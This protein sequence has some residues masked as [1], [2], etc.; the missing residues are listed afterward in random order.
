MLESMIA[1]RQLNKCLVG[2]SGQP[3][4]QIVGLFA[5]NTANASSPPILPPLPS[6]PF[7]PPSTHVGVLP[8]RLL[9]H[10]N[11]VSP[12]SL[13]SPPASTGASTSPCSRDRYSVKDTV[14][15]ST[16]LVALLTSSKKWARPAFSCLYSGPWGEQR[17]CGQQDQ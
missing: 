15:S 14:T 2:Q 4:G 17:G 13:L 7:P 12:L 3:L 11:V 8:P 5:W 16:P 1:T 9:V 6:L 10:L